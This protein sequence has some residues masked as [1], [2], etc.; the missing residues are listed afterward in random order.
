MKQIELLS[1]FKIAHDNAKITFKKKSN[2]LISEF[3]SFHGAG[4]EK[5]LRLVFYRVNSPRCIKKWIVVPRYGLTK[6]P[7]S[8]KIGSCMP[9][10]ST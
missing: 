5:R 4:E 7:L 2:S 1:M 9:T 3:I 8:F 6:V 10:S